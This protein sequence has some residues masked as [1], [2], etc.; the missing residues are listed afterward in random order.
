MLALVCCIHEG[1]RQRFVE[2]PNLGMLFQDSHGPLLRALCNGLWLLYCVDVGT[3]SQQGLSLANQ[4]A[5]M[6]T[7][8]NAP[9]L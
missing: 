9:T 6:N 1:G 3:P 2:T 7:A 4:H 8:R 5:L